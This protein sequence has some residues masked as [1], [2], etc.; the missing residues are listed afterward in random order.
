MECKTV[1]EHSAP[2]ALLGR[3]T[4]VNMTTILSCEM[5]MDEQNEHATMGLVRLIT[6]PA[7]ME[8][9]V[10]VIAS[11]CGLLT[12]EGIHTVKKHK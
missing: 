9:P 12:T 11:R 5:P 6:T 10:V 3:G 8:S 2:V 4:Q 7:K 1:F